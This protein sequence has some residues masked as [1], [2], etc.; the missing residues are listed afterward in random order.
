MAEHRIAAHQ[1]HHF[2]S[3]F[4][5]FGWVVT[6]ARHNP[7]AFR[8]SGSRANHI[9]ALPPHQVVM[10]RWSRQAAA[11]P[12]ADGMCGQEIVDVGNVLSS[13][14]AALAVGVQDPRRG[15]LDPQVVGMSGKV[16]RV[17]RLACTMR[18]NRHKGRLAA[19]LEHV[20][21]D[22]KAGP[23]ASR[24]ETEM[25]LGR[26]API[27]NLVRLG[28]FQSMCGRFA[29][30]LALLPPKGFG[31]TER[32]KGGQCIHYPATRAPCPPQT[33]LPADDSPRPL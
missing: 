33:A 4:C 8:T 14:K 1:L 18:R 15:N 6:L 2:V 12:F 24:R 27:G 26:N 31:A 21:T 32:H 10:G 28:S 19:S 3:G 25:T 17:Q 20:R 7:L 5:C 30:I 22:Q 23:L 16:Q 13:Y 11:N 29:N 9:R